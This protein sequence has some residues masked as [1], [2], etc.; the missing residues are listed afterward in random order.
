MFHKNILLS[1]ENVS[2]VFDFAYAEDVI[3]FA[4]SRQDIDVAI[5]DI[6][7]PVINGIELAEKLKKLIPEIHIIFITGYPEYK[8]EAMEHGCSGYLTKP[9]NA[10]EI[11]KELAF[12]MQ[13]MKTAAAEKVRMQCFGNFDVFINDNPVVFNLTKAKELLAYLVDRRGSTVNGG[14]LCA[15]LWEN[16]DDDNKNK[17]NLRQCWMSL[18]QTLESAG[19][20]NVL[21]K[22]W[23]TYGIDI[24]T[25]WCDAY[26]FEKGNVQVINSYKGEYMNQYSWAE[27]SKSIFSKKTEQ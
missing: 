13:N 23:N 25:F 27:N 17:N 1:I 19:A 16:N 11:K 4:K 6:N 8:S 26:E 12:V 7:L 2:E 14:E 24:K 21:K 10:D 5:L 9:T 20:D 22:G 15:V 3:E 18:K